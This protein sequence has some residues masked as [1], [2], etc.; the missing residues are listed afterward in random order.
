MWLTRASRHGYM[1]IGLMF[2]VILLGVMVTQLY[3]YYT[4]YKRLVCSQS[5]NA[6]RLMR[7]FEGIES[8]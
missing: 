2:N 1:L 8:G 4:T 7:V 5:A 6:R 3:I